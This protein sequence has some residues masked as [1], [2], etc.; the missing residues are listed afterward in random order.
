NSVISI[1]GVGGM[2]GLASQIMVRLGIGEVRI[3]DPEVFDLS[4]INRQL[5]A[6]INTI[7][8]S[9]AIETARL[10]REITDDFNL[11]VYPE[12]VESNM[13][14]EFVRGASIII[15]EIEF[16]NIGSCIRMH[17]VAR[18]LGVPIFNCLTVGFATYLHL[19]TPQSMPVE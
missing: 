3:A 4:N 8:K 16:W 18:A 5:A 13:V 17:Q 9:K 14:E 10:L 19:F 11:I 1:A 6:G 2:G 15:D 12:G 7:D